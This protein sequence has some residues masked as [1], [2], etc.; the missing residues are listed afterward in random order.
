M[1]SPAR[2]KSIE[3]AAIFYVWIATVVALMFTLMAAFAM[4]ALPAMTLLILSILLTMVNTVRD[5]HPAIRVIYRVG[6]LI[7]IGCVVWFVV[8]CFILFAV[9][10]AQR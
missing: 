4:D 9:A 1:K 2:R 3:G 8:D 5:V 6:I 10:A 7:A